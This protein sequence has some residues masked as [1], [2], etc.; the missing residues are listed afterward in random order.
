MTDLISEAREKAEALR[1]AVRSF[2]DRILPGDIK[3]KARHHQVLDKS[4]YVRWMRLLNDQGWAVGHWPKEHGGQAWSLLE[5]F[6]FEDQLAR[7]GC[8]WIIPFGVKYVGPVIYA[9]GTAEQ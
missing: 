4:D 7:L 2:Y 3:Q 1:A 5:R 6:A 9:F 8:P